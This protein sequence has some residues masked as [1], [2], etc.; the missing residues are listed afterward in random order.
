MTNN[1][2]E[3]LENSP[4]APYNQEHTPLDDWKARGK[5][6]GISLLGF[7]SDEDFIEA[8]IEAEQEAEKDRTEE[9]QELLHEIA[10]TL[11]QLQPLIGKLEDITRNIEDNVPAPKINF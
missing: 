10:F 4:L 1:Y 6:H 7:D 8:V 11:K 9:Y 3:N 5:K 2:P